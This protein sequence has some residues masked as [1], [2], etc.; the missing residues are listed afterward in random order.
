MIVISKADL[1]EDFSALKENFRQS[2][3]DIEVIGSSAV[4]GEGLVEIRRRLTVG[5]TGV[6]LGSSGVGKSSLT[7]LLLVDLLLADR[8]QKMRQQQKTSDIRAFDDKGRHTTTHRELFFVG[9]NAIDGSSATGGMIIDTPGLRE[10]S[11][12][13]SD[14]NV[15]SLFGSIAKLILQCKFSDCQHETEPHCA[16]KEARESGEITPEIWSSYQKLLR[17]AAFANRKI[18]KAAASE[19]KKKRKK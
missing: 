11:I 6:F 12:F 13:G 4:T 18:N 16:V 5:K 8:Q 14:E 19:Q 7:N 15:E 17:E 9:N 1:V 3:A 10:V 2:F